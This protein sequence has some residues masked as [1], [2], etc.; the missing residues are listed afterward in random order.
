MGKKGKG[1]AAAADAKAAEESPTPTDDTPAAPEPAAS[2]ADGGDAVEQEST[3]TV[4]ESGRA[5]PEI[6]GE[7][8]DDDDGAASLKRSLHALAVHVARVQVLVAE[9]SE[10]ATGGPLADAEP[11]EGGEPAD[12]VALGGRASAARACRKAQS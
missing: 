10:V 1:K 8:G 2:V 3:A 9:P 12:Y 6:G 11:K 4:Q 7:D 5:T